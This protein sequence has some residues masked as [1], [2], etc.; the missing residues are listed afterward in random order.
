MASQFAVDLV[1]G[2]KGDGKIKQAASGL[3]G[4]EGAAQKLNGTLRDS[5]GRFIGAGNAASG[6]ANGVRKF[7]DST[8]FAAR[9]AGK[10]KGSLGGLIGGLGASLAVGKIVRDFADLDTSLRR[11]GTVGGDVKSLDAGLGALSGKL[12]G[13]ANKADLAKASYQALSAGFLIQQAISRL[14]KLPRR[15]QLVAWR[16]LQASLRF[17]PRRLTLTR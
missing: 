16:M 10:L 9:A 8:H 3:K 12:G 2:L 14:L 11:L 5:R 4:V 17:L 6:A 7:G 1:F 15:R 13:V